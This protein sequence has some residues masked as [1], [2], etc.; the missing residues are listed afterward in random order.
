MP[1]YGKPLPGFQDQ[2]ALG[3]RNSAVD[4]F[5]NLL[6]ALWVRIPILT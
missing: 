3:A 5:F 2:Q 4:L 6:D 1:E